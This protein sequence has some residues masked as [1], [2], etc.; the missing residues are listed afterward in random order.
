MDHLHQ[1]YPAG[2]NCLPLCGYLQYKLSAQNTCLYK[3]KLILCSLY[4]SVLMCRIGYITQNIMHSNFL[5]KAC[6]TAVTTLFQMSEIKLDLR[7][8]K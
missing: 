5:E 1:R 8:R 3:K 2:C 7:E 4:K 6:M